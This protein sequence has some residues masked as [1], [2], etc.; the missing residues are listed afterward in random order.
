MYITASL[1][2]NVHDQLPLRS[3]IFYLVHL[4]V[5]GVRRNYAKPTFDCWTVDDDTRA[6]LYLLI[7]VNGLRLDIEILQSLI[8]GLAPNVAGIVAVA[9]I[10][11]INLSWRDLEAFRITH[12]D[13]QPCLV[14]LHSGP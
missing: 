5:Y 9:R 4:I 7:S 1:A 2:H 11:Q 8:S 6:M 12:L 13:N 3:L 10:H 14:L